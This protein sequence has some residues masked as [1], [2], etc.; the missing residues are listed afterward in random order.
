MAMLLY[1]QCVIFEI[2]QDEVKLGE[3]MPHGKLW[4]SSFFVHLSP[5]V[6]EK[7]DLESLAIASIQSKQNET[8]EELRLT[9]SRLEAT[10]IKTNE[11]RQRGDQERALIKRDVDVIRNLLNEVRLAN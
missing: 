1:Q 8:D 2:A 7:L 5:L 3:I 10:E 6:Q 11:A 9:L 4:P